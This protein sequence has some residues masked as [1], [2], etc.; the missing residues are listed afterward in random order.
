MKYH[1]IRLNI[2][3][4]IL[5]LNCNNEF[6]INIDISRS[7]MLRYYCKFCKKR[8]D[9]R[10][11]TPFKGTGLKIRDILDIILLFASN[12]SNTKICQELEL[13][14]RQ[15]PKIINLILRDL[16]LYMDNTISTT[17]NSTIV[18]LM[19]L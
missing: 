7:F 8:H 3:K 6:H 19:R 17:G 14:K 13:S 11:Y 12:N 18:K 4:I 5:C 10:K 1:L 16:K 2:V 9:V 15:C